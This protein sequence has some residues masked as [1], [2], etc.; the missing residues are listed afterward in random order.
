MHFC[1][2]AAFQYETLHDHDCD[3]YGLSMYFHSG[4]A[5]RIRELLD[6]SRELSGV[7]DKSFTYNSSPGNYISEAN[8]IEFSDVKVI[9]RWLEYHIHFYVLYISKFLI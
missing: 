2:S 8:H 6:V 3:A 9:T 4:Y 7:R 1:S 5:D